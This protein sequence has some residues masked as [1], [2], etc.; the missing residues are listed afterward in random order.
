MPSLVPQEQERF[1]GL[2]AIV[3]RA[4]WRS[5]PRP[6]DPTPP[7]LREVCSDGEPLSEPIMQY[8]FTDVPIG[9]LVR[10]EVEDTC[11]EAWF[12]LEGYGHARPFTLRDPYRPPRP[13]KTLLLQL[14]RCIALVL[15]GCR[16]TVESDGESGHLRWR[17]DAAGAPSLQ[18]RRARFA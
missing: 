17:S 10:V 13:D 1:F 18:A 9:G 2:Q 4:D 12:A 3:P 7:P 11:V 16:L 15:S 5:E 8:L 14:G 6:A